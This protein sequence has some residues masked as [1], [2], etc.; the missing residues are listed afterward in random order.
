[1]N[2][3]LGYDPFTFPTSFLQWFP[4]TVYIEVTY[5][6]FKIEDLFFKWEF[7]IVAN[8]KCKKYL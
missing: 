7:K 5:Q 3:C 1:M 2:V 8:G 6:N 4:M